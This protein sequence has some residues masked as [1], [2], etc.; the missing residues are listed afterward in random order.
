MLNIHVS[1]LICGNKPHKF[2]NYRPELPTEFYCLRLSFNISKFAYLVR[3]LEQN[4]NEGA[5][6]GGRGGGSLPPSCVFIA[7][8]WLE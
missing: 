8:V 3:S 4:L 7:T 6:G 2:C 5:M 1:S